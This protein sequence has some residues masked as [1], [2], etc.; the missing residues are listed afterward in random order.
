MK[1]VFAL[2]SVCTVV[3]L[4]GCSVWAYNADEAMRD[5]QADCRGRGGV[6]QLIYGGDSEGETSWLC[7]DGKTGG[8]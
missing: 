4:S 8:H 3:G 7:R 6:A 2:I 1:R 5:S